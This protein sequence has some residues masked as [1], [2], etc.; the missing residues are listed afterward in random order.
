MHIYYFQLSY[1]QNLLHPHFNLSSYSVVQQTSYATLSMMR[2]LQV[3]SSGFVLMKGHNKDS[4]ET[5]I[6]TSIY[7]DSFF[8]DGEVVNS[9]KG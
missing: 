2:R 9:S 4:P 6:H 1:G 5:K 3:E 8:Q 7:A